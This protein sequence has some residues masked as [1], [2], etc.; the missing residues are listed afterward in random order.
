MLFREFWGTQYIQSA[1]IPGVEW[2]L[3]STIG[4]MEFRVAIYMSF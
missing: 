4:S 3:V 2:I 1:D